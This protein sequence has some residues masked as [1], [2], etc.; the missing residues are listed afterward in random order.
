M[1]RANATRESVLHCRLDRRRNRELEELPAHESNNIHV[2]LS[3]PLGGRSLLHNVLSVR[4]SSRIGLK[5]MP[6]VSKID[7]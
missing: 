1:A 7:R 3:G 6:R 2:P 4:R 5:L